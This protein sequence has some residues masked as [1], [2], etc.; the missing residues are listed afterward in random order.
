MGYKLCLIITCPNLTEGATDSI[1]KGL[2]Y[3][4][5]YSK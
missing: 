3:Y 1:G 4:E 5:M 2:Y